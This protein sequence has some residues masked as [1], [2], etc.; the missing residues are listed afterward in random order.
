MS[1]IAIIGG[2]IAGMEA[3][4]R[5]SALNFEVHLIEKSFILGGHVKNW[6]MLFPDLSSATQL[7][8]QQ[9]NQLRDSVNIL[10]GIEVIRAS[11]TNNKYTLY[12]SDGS[13]NT[14]DAIILT[15]GFKLFP[16]QR[17]EEYGYSIYSN[18]ITSAELEEYFQ[19]DKPL[20]TKEHR[21]AERI[22]FI[23]CVGS[24]DDKVG[25]RYCSKVCC[26]TAV[27][28]AMETARR[29]PGAEIYLF[30]MD[31]RM[32]DRQFEDLYFQA[33]TQYGIRFIRG[34][35][36]EVS[37]KPD[38]RLFL[39]FEDTLLGKPLRLTTDMLVLMVGMEPAENTGQLARLF[40][41]PVGNDKFLLPKNLHQYRNLTNQPGIFL[42][43]CVS[44]PK[45]IGETLTD[46]RSAALEVYNYL[47]R[48]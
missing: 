14:F 48:N 46:A 24:R 32:F 22:A 19:T 16:A 29:N 44:G 18:V 13:S 45:T 42:A 26:V 12:F 9:K 47:N 23:H 25:N 10:L 6:H 40:N 7:V 11:Y 3:A 8:E 30:Y 5:L 41:V 37:E 4:I 39:K 15:T 28:Q 34:R 21:I 1:K 38:S 27:K 43:G 20:Y 2:G 17:K 36:S 33:Q 35:L 31:L